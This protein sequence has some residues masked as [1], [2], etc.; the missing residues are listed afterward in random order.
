LLRLPPSVYV[1]KSI[2]KVKRKKNMAVLPEELV[3]N[4]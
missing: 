3:Y 1:S 2:R 4:F